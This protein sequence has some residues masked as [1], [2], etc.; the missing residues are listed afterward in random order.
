MRRTLTAISAVALMAL[1]GCSGSSSPRVAST[2]ST[3]RNASAA[4]RPSAAHKTHTAQKTHA[5]HRTR[6]MFRSPAV[7]D[8]RLPARY[9][10]DGEDISPPLEWSDMPSSTKELAV[11]VLGLTPSANNTSE[12]SVAWALAG[13]KPGLHRLAAGEVPPGAHVG[14]ASGRRRYSVCPAKGKAESY[15]FALYAVPPSL[16]VP[17]NFT[18]VQLLRA[19]ASPTSPAGA[20]AGAAFRVS[21]RRR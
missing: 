9:T 2:S 18:G 19:I 12:V 15:D 3:V 11:L 13:I 10:C 14:S 20:T 17:A 4:G 7:V 6:T 5:A 8:G 1:G 21:Y 16:T